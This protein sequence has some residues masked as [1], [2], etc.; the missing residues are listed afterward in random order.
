MGCGWTMAV[1]GNDISP[2]TTVTLYNPYLKV[3]HPYSSADQAKFVVRLFVHL[4]ECLERH[5]ALSDGQKGDKVGSVR[6]DDDDTEEPP[7]AKHEANCQTAR[8]VFTT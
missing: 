8:S 3:V 1:F 2:F 5:R 4:L 7:A 6:G